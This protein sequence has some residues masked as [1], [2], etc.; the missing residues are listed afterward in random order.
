MHM[1]MLDEGGATM[2]RGDAVWDIFVF[3]YLHQRHPVIEVSV[4][5]QR[6]MVEV[7]STTS[8]HTPVEE[9]KISDQTMSTRACVMSLLKVVDQSS[10]L[11]MK[12]PRPA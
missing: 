12:I 4:A 11:G 1:L 6:I 3:R 5:G 7:A 8:M 2:T 9:H 10:A